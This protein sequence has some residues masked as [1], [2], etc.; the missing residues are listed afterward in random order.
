MLNPQETIQLS[1]ALS[2][3]LRHSAVDQQLDI[4]PDGYVAVADLL[5]RP[6]FQEFSLQDLQ[7]VVET[8][9]KKRYELTL[10]DD[11]YYIR[12]TQGHSIKTVTHQDLLEEVTHL[13]TPVIHG[14]TQKAWAS[15]KVQGLSTM[16]RN[17][18]H[19]A[20]G[21]PDDPT[22]SSGI[23]K[24]S[25]VFIYI[26]LQEAQKDGIVFYRSKNNV[27][28]SSGLNGFVSPKYFEKVHDNQG[29]D[30]V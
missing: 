23:R 18:I 10:R 19:F 24:T 16:R 28:L 21:L 27:I 30:L 3:V 15:I 13:T 22:V 29:Q 8:N 17:H 4:S 20:T 5:A 11:V 12:A 26:R 2:K 25:D 14:T 1:K 9:N 7:H 6:R